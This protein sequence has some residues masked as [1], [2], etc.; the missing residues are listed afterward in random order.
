MIKLSSASIFGYAVAY[1]YHLVHR[2]ES[3]VLVAQIERAYVARHPV[4]G[5]G[6]VQIVWYQASEVV[7]NDRQQL[8]VLAQPCEKRFQIFRFFSL[9]KDKDYSL[10]MKSMAS[11][12]L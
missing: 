5:I 12:V 8:W 4:M 3:N 7:L 1:R 2:L 11:C 9:N 10:L 6:H